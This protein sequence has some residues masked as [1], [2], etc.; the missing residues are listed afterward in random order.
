[1]VKASEANQK[2]YEERLFSLRSDV[3]KDLGEK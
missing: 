2:R 3:E 1:M